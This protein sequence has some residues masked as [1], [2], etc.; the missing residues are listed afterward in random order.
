M[1]CFPNCL[2][3]GL[4]SQLREDKTARVTGYGISD[5]GSP[6]IAFH[7]VQTCG[8]ITPQCVQ[9]SLHILG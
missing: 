2:S 4:S 1:R 3:T 6:P 8:V 7:L 5:E 9:T